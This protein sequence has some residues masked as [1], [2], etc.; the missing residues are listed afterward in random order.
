M[1]FVEPV[2]SNGGRPL[3]PYRMLVEGATVT[4]RGSFVLQNFME[5]I[6]KC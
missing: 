2:I 5:K 4:N 6:R 3:A 1:I